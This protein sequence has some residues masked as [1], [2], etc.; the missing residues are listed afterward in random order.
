M[1]ARAQETWDGPLRGRLA[2]GKRWSLGADGQRASLL[3]MPVSVLRRHWW[4]FAALDAMARVAAAYLD[5]WHRQREAAALATSEQVA[6]EVLRAAE[7]RF[8]VGDVAALDVN[9]ARAERARAAA[10]RLTAGATAAA[11][12]GE[13]RAVIGLTGV[14]PITLADP[15]ALGTPPDVASLI[16]ALEK[17]PDLRVLAS[18]I[19]QVGAELRLAAIF[20]QP[21]WAVGAQY[22]R[23][24]GDNIVLGGLRI[25]FP[26]FNKAQEDVALL[27]AR[28]ERLRQ[29]HDA[30]R[31]S[32]EAQLRAEFEAY[33]LQAVAVDTL[34]REALPAT[35]DN[36]VLARRSYEVGQI[37]VADWLVLRREAVQIQREFLAQ[38]LDLARL[39]LQLDVTSGVWQ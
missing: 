25:R 24:E 22:G 32:L 38:R 6:A 30:R 7:R 27:N 23:E 1:S 39:R 37:S 3:R 36:E 26:V 11:R 18:E 12:L 5:A 35:A 20:R 15:V 2:R 31:R 4:R 14:E 21:E 29:Q 10:E 28:A 16:A 8:S 9:A 34:E 13:L 33:R 19:E 17:R